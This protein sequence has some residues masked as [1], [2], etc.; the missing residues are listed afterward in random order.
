MYCPLRG[1]A[2]E[3]V[4]RV[5]PLHHRFSLEREG[6]RRARDEMT[7]LSS[8]SAQSFTYI[9]TVRSVSGAWG[10]ELKLEVMMA[11]GLRNCFISR[12][13]VEER[14]RAEEANREEMAN[15]L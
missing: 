7:G 13:L 11:T 2:C 5:L 15:I 4:D 12:E 6:G 14:W 10:V 1:R 3:G 8:I 9:H